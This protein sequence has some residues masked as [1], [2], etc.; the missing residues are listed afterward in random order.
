[1]HFSADHRHIHTVLNPFLELEHSQWSAGYDVVDFDRGICCESL[2]L[3]SS[4]SS[5]RDWIRTVGLDASSWI[6]IPRSMADGTDALDLGWW[7]RLLAGNI[8]FA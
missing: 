6:A 8:V 1:M 3:T 4:E 5:I 2:L 7:H